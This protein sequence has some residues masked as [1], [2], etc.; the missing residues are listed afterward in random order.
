MENKEQVSENKNDI[1]TVGVGTVN[2]GTYGKISTSGVCTAKGE[3]AADEIKSAG[4]FTAKDHVSAGKIK[5]GGTATFAKDL[6]ATNAEFS[7][8]CKITGKLRARDVKISGGFSATDVEAETV[9]ASGNVHV[10]GEMNVGTL[11]LCSPN[12][13]IA[14]LHADTVKIAISKINWYPFRGVSVAKIGVVECTDF[15]AE[16]VRAEKVSCRNATIGKYCR[17]KSLEYSGTLTMDPE[18][19]VDEVTK[20]E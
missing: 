1:K 3:I 15:S 7:G 5:T 6:D 13:N 9:T 18:A 12:T 17:I 10:S 20:A 4:V 19:E 14:T 16:G 2:Q 11:E 8:S